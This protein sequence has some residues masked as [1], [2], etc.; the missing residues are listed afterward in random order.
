MRHFPFSF[1]K[2]N[3][4]FLPR[5]ESSS[6]P[7]SG[8]APVP[9]SSTSNL[10]LNT[11]T[12]F[13]TTSYTSPLI[14]NTLTL[15]SPGAIAADNYN[16]WVWCN[17]I[18]VVDG[19][20]I[21]AT[22]P[23]TQPAMAGGN[24]FASCGPP[25]YG[26]NGGDGASGAGGGGALSDSGST[27][28]A[29]GSLIGSTGATGEFSGC[30]ATPGVGGAG[31]GSTY[32]AGCPFTFP[33]GGT[34]ISGTPTGPWGAGGQGAGIGGVSCLVGAGGGGGGGGGGLLVVVCNEVINFGGYAVG[35]PSGASGGTGFEIPYPAEGG[36]GGVIAIFAKKYPGLSAGHFQVYGGP[37][38]DCGGQSGGSGNITIYE[39]SHDGKSILS[40]H[41]NVTDSWNN[42]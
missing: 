35:G 28:P 32:I 23:G 2:S 9:V 29:P 17:A 22:E 30:G 1:W 40:A 25:G 12:V 33:I 13:Y 26:G 31:S 10:T 16:I 20:A 6:G 11:S 19:T 24:G 38:T 39:V 37:S 42:L 3:G 4:L 5:I 7:F 14:A 36:S 8:H 15:T 27:N 41:T 34:G 18:N 21:V